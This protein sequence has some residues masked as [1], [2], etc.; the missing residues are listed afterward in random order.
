MARSRILH[1]SWCK[2]EDLAVCSPL[3]RLLYRDMHGVADRKGRVEDRPKRIA[4]ECLP[5]DHGCDVDALL[6]ELAGA[7]FIRRYV[8]AGV[9]YIEIRDFLRTQRPHVNEIP[10]RIPEPPADEIN[11]GSAEHDQDT[12]KAVLGA[13]DPV[14]I[15]GS[16]SSFGS[17]PNGPDQELDP[18]G[19][20]GF[21]GRAPRAAE[22]G[23]ARSRKL[24]HCVK[25]A[26]ETGS[27]DPDYLINDAIFRFGPANPRISRDEVLPLLNQRK[28]G[29]IA[30]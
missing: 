12:T 21:N 7:G 24:A 18:K 2:D 15:S 17:S 9:R 4:V 20:S 14:S 5:Y 23:D 10:S 16:G 29:R 11:Q 8:A 27:D 28:N 22:K 19:R 30:S 13:L 1:A 3:A 25:Q 26:E 6:N